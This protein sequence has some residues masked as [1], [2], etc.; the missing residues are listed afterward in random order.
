LVLSVS[1]NCVRFL[2][3]EKIRSVKLS[4]NW[5]SITNNNNN[6]NKVISSEF[7]VMRRSMAN[8][9][10]W[11]VV[12]T[13]NNCVLSSVR[14]VLS[15]HYVLTDSSN[16]DW[17]WPETEVSGNLSLSLLSLVSVI[18]TRKNNNNNISNNNSSNNENEEVV[19]MEH[20]DFLSP[21]YF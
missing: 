13:A 15:Y 18:K 2:S 19:T 12:L 8:P 16:R 7:I 4:S 20:E 3:A 5:T 6:N 11:R 10:V 21:S 1:L 9:S 14:N 17:H